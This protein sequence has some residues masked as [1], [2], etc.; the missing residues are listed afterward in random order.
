MRP[1]SDNGGDRNFG[2]RL[3]ADAVGLAMRTS[4]TEIQ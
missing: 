3:P 2:E 4:T 1:L